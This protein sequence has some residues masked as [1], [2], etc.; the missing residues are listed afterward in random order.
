MAPRL[1]ALAHGSSLGELLPPLPEQLAGFRSLLRA[2]R[3]VVILGEVADAFVLPEREMRQDFPQST[4]MRDYRAEVAGIATEAI[5]NLIDGLTADRETRSTTRRSSLMR[6]MTNA[7]NKHDQ[8]FH[9]APPTPAAVEQWA[10]DEKQRLDGH[11]LVQY[12]EQCRNAAT[13]MTSAFRDAPAASRRRA[14][15]SFYRRS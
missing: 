13:E 7:I 4:A 1:P 6:E 3:E 11:E 5:P 2:E 9:V 14:S 15:S 12:E 10:A 8:D